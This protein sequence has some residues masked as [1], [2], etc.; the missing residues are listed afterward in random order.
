L[1]KGLRRSLVISGGDPLIFLQSPIAIIFFILTIFAV[2]SLTKGKLK[3]L[4][5]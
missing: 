3:K 1:E 2:I 5:E 4:K